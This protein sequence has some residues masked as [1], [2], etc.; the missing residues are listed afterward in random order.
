MRRRGIT[1]L[2]L[3]VTFG[4]FSLLTAVLLAALQE[5]S[6]ILGRASG[7]AVSQGELSKCRLRVREDLERSAFSKVA[8][9]KMPGGDGDAIWCLSPVDPAS[10]LS[11]RKDDG[12]PF[13][14]NHVLYYLV[15]PKGHAKLYGYAC[16]GGT[17]T[18]GYDDRCPH[19]VLIRKVIDAPPVT[20]ASNEATE[21][22]LMTSSQI[23][24]YLTAPDGFNVDAMKS[25]PGV[26]SVHLRAHSLLYF[27]ARLAPV[28]TSPREISLDLRA[29][30][31]RRA[32]KEVRVGSVSL[33]QGRFTTQ[34]LFSAFPALP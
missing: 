27:R 18:D 17:D 7:T 33:A 30:D 24:Q 23:N 1:L 28:A 12:S 6:Q 14:V 8:V 4:L 19:K 13:F 10:G 2:E 22:A 20:D 34:C 21:E 5:G 11:L 9:R 32:E 29:A 31:I 26:L 15:I 16:A 25:E 3:V